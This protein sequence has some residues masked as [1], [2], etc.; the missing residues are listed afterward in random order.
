MIPLIARPCDKEQL[1]KSVYHMTLNLKHLLASLQD[2]G[3]WDK[4]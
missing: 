4:K 3:G 1:R 2:G